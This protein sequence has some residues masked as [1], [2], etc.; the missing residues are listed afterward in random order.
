M[1]VSSL[2]SLRRTLHKQ[3]ISCSVLLLRSSSNIELFSTVVSWLF[4][5]FFFKNE[6]VLLDSFCYI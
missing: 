4:L 1:K 6:M 3:N 2:T 5:F